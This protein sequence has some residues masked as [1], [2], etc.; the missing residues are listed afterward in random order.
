MLRPVLWPFL[1]ICFV[2]VLCSCP[3]EALRLGLEVVITPGGGR[4]ADTDAR[5]MKTAAAEAV[6]AA[7]AGAVVAGAVAAA[8]SPAAELAAAAAVASL[9]LSLGCCLLAVGRPSEAVS[10]LEHAA[11]A[12]Q[13][14]MTAVHSSAGEDVLAG[15][16]DIQ[17]DVLSSLAGIRFP[18]P[19]QREPSICMQLILVPCRGDP[20]KG[21]FICPPQSCG[22]FII[23]TEI[24][25][26]PRPAEAYYA[27]GDWANA[28]SVYS[29]L[30]MT[31]GN[32]TPTSS[33]QMGVSAAGES[34]LQG[35]MQGGV[36]LHLHG[37]CPSSPP[38]LSFGAAAEGTHL[39]LPPPPEAGSGPLD[40]RRR[41]PVEIMNNLGNALRA[42]GRMDEA[43]ECYERV[44]QQVGVTYV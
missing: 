11:T 24:T 27:S 44:C 16:N 18:P 37:E 31:A 2:C 20:L 25:V 13:A 28:I 1:T 7:A 8:S 15:T 32:G 41:R 34:R 39:P 4:A 36:P 12:V 10:C 17:T 40:H 21:Y 14:G 43:A 5:P 3:K 42:A 9:R 35:G 19:L 38:E 26:S 6:G 23:A 22:C 30:L 33:L 29:T